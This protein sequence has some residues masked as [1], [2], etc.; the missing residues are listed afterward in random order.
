MTK[1]SLIVGVIL[2]LLSA[3]NL[4]ADDKPLILSVKQSPNGRSL[5]IVGARFDHSGEPAVTLEGKPLEVA[6]FTRSVVR[7]RLPD[8]I[9]TGTYLLTVRTADDRSADFHVSVGPGGTVAGSRADVYTGCLRPNGAIKKVAI[10]TEPATTCNARDTQIS[11]NEEGPEGPPGADGDDG[12]PGPPGA[13]GADGVTGYE[14][15][16]DET[17]VNADVSKQLRVDCP[18]GKKA[19]G[20]GWGV[21]D[22]TSAILDGRATYF[23]PRFDGSGWL[24]NAQNNSGFAPNGSSA[25]T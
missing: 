5:L 25:C 17:A 19:L 16:F 21:L 6:H 11:W 8:E 10:G 20:A 2:C 1:R 9:S 4:Y 12:A 15:V 13:P 24:T 23:Q 14:V 3:P 22:D 7:A 18:G